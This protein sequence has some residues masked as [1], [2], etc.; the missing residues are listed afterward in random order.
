MREK[1]RFKQLNGWVQR[2]FYAAAL[3]LKW[4]WSENC[5]AYSQAVLRVA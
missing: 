4:P 1:V 5:S 2:Q 3:W